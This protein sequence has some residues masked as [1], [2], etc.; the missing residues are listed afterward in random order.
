M[1]VQQLPA[2]A[3]GN[4]PLTSPAIPVPRTLESAA[5]HAV[6]EADRLDL[7]GAQSARND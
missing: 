2:E 5:E 1:N 4:R 7:I 6:D 3:H